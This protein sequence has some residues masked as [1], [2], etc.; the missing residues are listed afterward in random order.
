VKRLLICQRLS[1]YMT[2]TSPNTLFSWNVLMIRFVTGVI[3]EGALTTT[4]LLSPLVDRYEKA[5]AGKL[6]VGVLFRC[7][8]HWPLCSIFDI[9]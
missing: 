2:E 4:L 6:D 9:R 1:A 8:F 3:D 7:S 5:F